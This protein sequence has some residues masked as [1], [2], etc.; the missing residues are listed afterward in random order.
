[1]RPPQGLIE[2]ETMFEDVMQLGAFGG[3]DVAVDGAHV[4]EQR[5]RRQTI[6]VVRETLL[7]FAAAGQVGEE[8]LQR[9]KHGSQMAWR[10]SPAWHFRR[11]QSKWCGT[12]Y[13]EGRCKARGGMARRMRPRPSDPEGAA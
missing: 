8:I 5:G 2:I 1:M 13:R 12:Y 10:P 9:F 4:Y 6:V 11:I 3:R 7:A